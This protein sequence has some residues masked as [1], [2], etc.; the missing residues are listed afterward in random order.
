ME[1]GTVR[2]L[3]VTMPEKKAKDGLITL[4]LVVAL[5]GISFYIQK[6]IRG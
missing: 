1:E 2:I 5:L 3:G 6:I 4:Q